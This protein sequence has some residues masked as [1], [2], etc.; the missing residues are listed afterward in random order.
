M[1]KSLPAPESESEGIDSS[2]KSEWLRFAESTSIKGVPKVLRS[3]QLCVR[4]MWLFAVVFGASFAVYQ[5]Y[6]I[7]SKYLQ[8]KTSLQIEVSLKLFLFKEATIFTGRGGHLSVTA[9][10]QFFLV[11]PFA[12]VKKFWFPPIAYG[13]NIWSP[14]LATPKNSGPPTK[15]K[16]HPPSHNQ[17]R[18]QWLY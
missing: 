16:E 12:Y 13:E 14:P 3:S 2:L 7:I 11:P 17:W 10:R 6:Y 15:V 1:Q 9:G 5:V 8:Y 4:A 18:G